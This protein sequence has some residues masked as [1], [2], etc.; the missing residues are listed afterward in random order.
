[1]ISRTWL[2]ETGIYYIFRMFMVQFRIQH[3]L[4]ER[5]LGDQAS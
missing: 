4:S 3:Y 5:I 2:I 1:M